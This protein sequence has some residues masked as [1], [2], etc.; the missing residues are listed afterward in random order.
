M[1]GTKRLVR[2]HF[3]K[4]QL[5]CSAVVCKHDDLETP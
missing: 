3:D 5:S 1:A 2:M 4:R